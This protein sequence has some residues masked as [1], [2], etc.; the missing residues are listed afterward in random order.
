MQFDLHID[1]FLIKDVSASE[2]QCVQAAPT[3]YI[4]EPGRVFLKY[5]LYFSHVFKHGGFRDRSSAFQRR[6]TLNPIPKSS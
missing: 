2:G 5:T 1:L 3:I 4:T 6:Y